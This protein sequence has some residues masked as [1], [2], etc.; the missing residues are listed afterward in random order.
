M[1]TECQV[2]MM[3]C[4]KALRWGGDENVPSNE[5]KGSMNSK[6]GIETRG[7]LMGSLSIF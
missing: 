6:K 5:R 2:K 7:Q 3:A 1:G 4:T